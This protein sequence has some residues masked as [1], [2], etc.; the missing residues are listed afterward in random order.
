MWIENQEYK[1]LYKG[2]GNGKVKCAVE[3]AVNA[4]RGSRGIAVLFLDVR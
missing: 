1:N 2:K 4:Q 3:Q